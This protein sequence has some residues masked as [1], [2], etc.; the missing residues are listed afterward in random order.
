[1]EQGTQQLLGSCCHKK[2]RAVKIE[3]LLG[4]QLVPSRHPCTG[5]SWNPAGIPAQ[6][7]AGTKQASLHRQQLELSRN[8]CTGSSWNPA[9]IP[10]QAAAG[11][12]QASVHRQQQSTRVRSLH[13]GCQAAVILFLAEFLEMSPNVLL[14]STTR[15]SHL[16]RFGQ[17]QKQCQ[18]AR[19]VLGCTCAGHC[20]LLCFLSIQSPT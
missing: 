12:Q 11:T 8:P 4:L 18:A 3:V 5:N 1:M 14:L 10:A 9:G 2:P 16:I 6:A 20:M 15:G 13:C 17:N 19:Y 7:A